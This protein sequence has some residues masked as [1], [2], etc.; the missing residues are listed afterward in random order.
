MSSPIRVLLVDDSPLARAMLRAFLEGED[1]IEIVGEAG[2]GQEAID[3]VRQLRPSLVTMDLEMPVMGGLDAIEAIMCSKAVPILVVSSIA[4]AHNAYEAVRRGALEVVSKPEYTPEQAAEFVA[5][6]R[7]LAG[8]PVIT[9]LRSHK[10]AP[11]TAASTPPLPTL[12]AA[13]PASQDYQ[14][15]VA[16]ASS[17]G[18]PQALAALLPQ[19]PPSFPWPILIAQHISDGFAAGMCDWLASLCQL[20]VRLAS[21]GMILQAGTVYV[22]PSEQ[23]LVVTPGRRLALVERKPLDIYRPSCDVLLES[24]ATVFGRH[25]IGLILT[26]MGSDGAKGMAAL[27]RA[28]ALTLGQDEGSSVIYGMNRVAIDAGSVLQ[29]LPLADIAP[30][31]LQLAGGQP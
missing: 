13:P 31:L 15:V 22:S 8:V 17:T 30:T 29:V 23:H 4:D 26:G 14:R 28:S 9:H 25:A 1:G 21:D 19:L 6:V 10:Q 7:L 5:K 2:N 12:G 16:I 20:P 24:V 27:H 11:A 18:G 3:L